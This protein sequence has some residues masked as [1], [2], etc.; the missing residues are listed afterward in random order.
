[1]PSLSSLFRQHN[2]NN[3]KKPISEAEKVQA[4]LAVLVP[5]PIP[6]APQ[7]AEGLE[8]QVDNVDAVN[9]ALREAE[10]QWEVGAAILNLP[11]SVSRVSRADLRRISKAS[12]DLLNGYCEQN[13]QLLQHNQDNNNRDDNVPAR[14]R[15]GQ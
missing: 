5:E 13:S 9:H 8:N 6:N 4:R 15:R 10:L 14:P 1:M 3:N 12:N 7:L 11:P 2:R